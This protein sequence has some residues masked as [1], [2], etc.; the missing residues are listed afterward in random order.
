MKHEAHKAFSLGSCSALVPFSLLRCSF[1]TR[2]QRGIGRPRD[3]ICDIE[4]RKIGGHGFFCANAP[5]FVSRYA[6]QHRRPVCQTL[7]ARPPG[8]LAPS[9]K[10]V[11]YLCG[12]DDAAT[13]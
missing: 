3:Y 13:S 9:V 2:F 8:A 12:R 10:S 6:E 5:S 4:I 1:M 11:E 7:V